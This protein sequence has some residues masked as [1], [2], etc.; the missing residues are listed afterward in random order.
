LV[1]VT[2]GIIGERL[3]VCVGAVGVGSHLMRIKLALKYLAK[4]KGNALLWFSIFL[5]W[6]SGNSTRL[7]L[8]YNFSLPYELWP[9]EVPLSPYGRLRHTA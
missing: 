8:L 6:L 7:F 5:S 3:G 4:M 2:L 1:W 9:S